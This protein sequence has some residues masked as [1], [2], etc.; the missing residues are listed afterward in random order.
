VF[1]SIW[2]PQH[3]HI[4]ESIFF[5]FFEVKPLFTVHGLDPELFGLVGSGIIILNPDP[6]A[7]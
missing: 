6:D 5:Y 3:C 1:N 4:F 2:N 7:E